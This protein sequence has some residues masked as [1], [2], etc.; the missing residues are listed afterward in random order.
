MDLTASFI[1]IGIVNFPKLTGTYQGG[2]REALLINCHLHRDLTVQ[3]LIMR[4]DGNAAENNKQTLLITCC[5]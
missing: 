1:R 4:H 3:D 2:L 5:T